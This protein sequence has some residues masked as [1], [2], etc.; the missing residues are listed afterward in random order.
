MPLPPSTDFTDLSTTEGEFKVAI[1][2]LRNWLAIQ[3]GTVDTHSEIVSG[4]GAARPTPT[5]SGWIRQNTTSGNIDVSVGTSWLKLSLST[6]DATWK[7]LTDATVATITK[8]RTTNA[9][10]RI[11][12][13]CAS[14]GN[15]S[16]GTDVDEVFI[17]STGTKQVRIHINGTP[18]F[19]ID[20]AGNLIV[21]GNV[22]ANGVV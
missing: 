14:T 19:K 22:T 16:L 11:E 21:T 3:L 12:V 20:S 17:K 7:I 13:E 6:I 9:E 10:G 15:A 4:T 5:E 8:F 18:V 1:T 2:A